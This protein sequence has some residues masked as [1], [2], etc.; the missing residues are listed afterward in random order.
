MSSIFKNFFKKL[1]QRGYIR[2][3]LSGR[4]HRE[5]LLLPGILQRC[6]GRWRSP[7]PSAFLQEGGRCRLLFIFL[8]NDLMEQLLILRAVTALE[9]SSDFSVDEVEVPTFLEKKKFMGYTP[10]E[11]WRYFLL[12]A[13]LT[14]DS[15]IPKISAISVIRSGFK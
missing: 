10:Q 9:G 2:Y 4:W 12:T 3:I 7:F 15:W 14:V 8:S 5:F 1:F 6:G 13:R 11:H